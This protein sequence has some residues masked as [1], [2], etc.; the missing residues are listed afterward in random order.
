MLLAKDLNLVPE[1]SMD[2]QEAFVE[3]DRVSRQIT[4]KGL[5]EASHKWVEVARKIRSKIAALAGAT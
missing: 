1:E 4:D 3:C 2:L 5:C